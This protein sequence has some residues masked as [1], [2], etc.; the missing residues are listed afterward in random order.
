MNSA[1]LARNELRNP[2]ATAFVAL[3]LVFGTLFAFLT[4][5]FQVPDEPSHYLRAYAISEGSFRVRLYDRAPA[6]PL[7]ENLL[8]F[9]TELVGS[10]TGDQRQLIT[11]GEIRHALRYRLQPEKRVLE[12][13]PHE[14]ADPVAL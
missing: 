8:L 12:L 6:Q 14:K 2:I 3:S 10:R 5:P 11:V 1:A 13:V 9:A 7:P 4:P